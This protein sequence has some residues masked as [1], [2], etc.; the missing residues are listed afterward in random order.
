MTPMCDHPFADPL[1][2]AGRSCAA[3]RAWC[4]LRGPD[5]G[6]LRPTAP[7][8][9]VRCRA[10]G[11]CCTLVAKSGKEFKH[12]DAPR[13]GGAA[14]TES[15]RAR[16][17]PASCRSPPTCF[18]PARQG[19]CPK[20]RPVRRPVS[21]FALHRMV[22]QSSAPR[23]SRSPR[24]TGNFCSSA[25]SSTSG[26]SLRRD[27]RLHTRPQPGSPGGLRTPAGRDGPELTGDL[28]PSD[29]L[30][31][32]RICQGRPDVLVKR[33]GVRSVYR[34]S[35]LRGRR[36][37][38]GGPHRGEPHSPGRLLHAP[39][40][41][42]PGTAA[43]T[44][45]PE[46]T[47]ITSSARSGTPNTRR[48]SATRSPGRA[49]SSTASSVRARPTTAGSGPGWPGQP[50]GAQAARHLAR[51]AGRPRLKEK[52]LSRGLRKVWD[53]SS[54]SPRS[55]AGIPGVGRATAERLVVNARAIHHGISS[56][57]AAR[58]CSSRALPGSVPRPRGN[59]PR[60][61]SRTAW[62]RWTT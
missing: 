28:R 29:V 36:D 57:W 58:P 47:G 4:V 37:Q 43:G 45:H 15:R 17:D 30:S 9:R 18:R 14:L 32:P 26:V 50:H 34:R 8:R 12:D 2:R 35:R 31:A 19:V 42:D 11:A 40:L 49:A 61:A 46:S 44:V 10:G 56:R 24:P 21:P 23:A 53:L 27:G 7:P 20:A 48:R 1:P 13:D 60:Q 59:G 38:A 5:E 54:A 6:R 41:Q 22:R 25:A 55:L 16:Y 33:E 39:A 3:C 62:S 51:P 52:L